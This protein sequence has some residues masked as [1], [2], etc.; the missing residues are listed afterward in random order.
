MEFYTQ[1]DKGFSGLKNLGNTC[2]L[3]SCIQILSHTPEL[4]QCL[5]NCDEP[6]DQN[7][8]LLRKEYC[9]LIRL[10]WS[11]NCI[12][13]PN[14]FIHVVHIVAR[15]KQ[16]DL[17]TG[18]SQNDATEFLQFFIDSFGAP[19]VEKIFYGK[20]I[21]TICRDISSAPEIV[22]KQT[23]PF[24][25]LNVPIPPSVGGVAP[26][27]YDCISKFTECETLNGDNKWYNEKTK[28]YEDAIKKYDFE[29]FPPILVI[30]FKRFHNIHKNEILV[31]FD[32]FL[33]FSKVGVLPPSAPTPPRYELYG[34]C[35]HM[36]NVF[37]GHY[38]AFVKH[39]A[40]AGGAP[41]QWI[42]YNDHI[43]E[44]VPEFSNVVSSHA[45]CLFYR[46]CTSA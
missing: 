15:N 18:F 11:Q 38:T 45:Y 41:A 14:R 2:F 44:K 6:S 25:I 43:V 35:N 16:K 32:D 36:G 4:F 37:F 9:D 10:M 13:S 34:V 26:T 3:N 5:I 1:N 39:C 33:D 19:P 7:G 42:H 29:E 8:A 28:E 17:F 46:K 22:S 12:V 23:E 30:T 21:S 24:F 31:Q 40:D 20:V 27:I